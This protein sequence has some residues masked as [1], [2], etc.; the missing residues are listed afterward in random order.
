[1]REKGFGPPRK[2]CNN[3]RARRFVDPKTRSEF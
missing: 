1:M 2:V 3:Q